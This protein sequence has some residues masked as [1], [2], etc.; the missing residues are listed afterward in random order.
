MIFTPD[1]HVTYIL[2]ANVNVLNQFQPNFRPN[3]NE[4]NFSTTVK[5]TTAFS[6]FLHNLSKKVRSPEEPASSG[7]AHFLPLNLHDR[8]CSILTGLVGKENVSFF[9]RGLASVQQMLFVVN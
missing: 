7:W 3:R 8:C 5:A 2:S 9:Y 4:T 6:I 1:D